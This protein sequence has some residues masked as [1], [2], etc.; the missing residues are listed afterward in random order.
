MLH[1]LNDKYLF[2]K[3]QTNCYHFYFRF[4]P[5]RIIF[6]MEKNKLKIIKLDFFFQIHIIG[7]QNV[8]NLKLNI[9]D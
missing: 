8:Y 6:F 5:E 4:A 7:R 9:N 3:I 2:V 1:S